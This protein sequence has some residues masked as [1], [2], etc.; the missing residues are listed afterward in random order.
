MNFTSLVTRVAEE[1]GLDATADATKLG[2]WVNEAYR[3]IAG[4]R[5]WPWMLSAATVQTTPDITTLTAS[6][7][8][9]STSVTLSATYATSLA[10]DYMIQFT[11]TSDDWYLITAHTAG[12]SA[13]T[14]ANGYTGSTNLS[15]GTCLIRRIY[16]SLAT[17]VDRVIDMTQAI[18]KEPLIFTDPR[19]IDRILPD[20]TATGTPNTYS[21][22]GFDSS[23]SWRAYFYPLP[24]AKINIQYRYYKRITDIATTENPLLPPKFHQAI[25]YVALAMFAHPYIDDT[26]MGNAERRARMLIEELTRELSA[27]QPNRHP[28]IQPWDT[29]RRR[30]PLRP[31]F[32]PNYDQRWS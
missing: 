18:T 29:R 16:Y 11:S 27:S 12:T 25:V 26:R 6:V 31:Q 9:A 3:L 32:P 21:L 30:N 15:S 13:V 23:N 1:T 28:V 4:M 24:S 20:P 14:I 8:A 5:E 7:N 10:N 17:D 19:E 2:V 22:V